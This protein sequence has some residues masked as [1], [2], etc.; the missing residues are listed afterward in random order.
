MKK[1]LGIVALLAVAVFAAN[2]VLAQE[3]KSMKIDE[4]MTD[5]E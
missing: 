2:D 3:V 4:V 5:G 1:L